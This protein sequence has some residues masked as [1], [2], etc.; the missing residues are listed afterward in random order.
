M[1]SPC[2]LLDTLADRRQVYARC[3]ENTEA[4]IAEH[5]HQLV[6]VA[7][8]TWWTSTASGSTGTSAAAVRAALRRVDADTAADWMAD[9]A[10]A[11]LAYGTTLLEPTAA[12][13]AARQVVSGL[14]DDA[15]WWSNQAHITATSRGWTPVTP[16]TFD[17]VIAGVGGTHFVVLLQVAED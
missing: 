3:G 1:T 6:L 15:V 16:C 11:D 9:L 2:S 12:A 14:G 7:Q 4:D 10:A 5:V 13:D 8:E 17:G